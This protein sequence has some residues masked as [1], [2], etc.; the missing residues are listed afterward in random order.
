ML[1]A[2]IFSALHPE[3]YSSNLIPFPEHDM[4]QLKDVLALGNDLYN[5]AIRICPQIATL[6]H[7][8]KNSSVADDLLG[9]GMSGSGASCFALSTS[10]NIVSQLCQE[11]NA[12]GFWA[13]A[14]SLIE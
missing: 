12:F 8:M 2:T 4:L 1:T 14:T 3:N 9:V 13:V 10:K 11:L 6:I 7:R 5:P